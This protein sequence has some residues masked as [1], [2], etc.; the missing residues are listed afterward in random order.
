[1]QVNARERLKGKDHFSFGVFQHGTGSAFNHFGKFLL[2]LFGVIAL[3][4]QDIGIVIDGQPVLHIPFIVLGIRLERTEHIEDKMG[5]IGNIFHNTLNRKIKLIVDVQ[6]F[7]QRVVFAKVSFGHVLC[8]DN[9]IGGIQS[10]LGIAFYHR[11]REDIKHR[12]ID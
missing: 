7:L 4:Q 1:M 2:Q 5:I 12:I 6:D 8:N 3:F 11:K 9:R 10:C